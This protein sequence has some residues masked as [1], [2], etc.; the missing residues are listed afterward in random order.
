[1]KYKLLLLALLW[2]VAATAQK[3][4]L[5][6]AELS[7]TAPVSVDN[8]QPAKP[9]DGLYFYGFQKGDV[10]LVNVEPEKAGQTINLE[11]QDYASGSVVYSSKS[12]KKVKDLRLTVPQKAVYSFILTSATG[13]PLAA[14]LSIKRLPAADELRHFNPNITWKNVADT[15]WTTA[16]EKVLVKGELTPT[17][18]IDK[19][20]RVA[21]MANLNPSRVA[22]PFKLPANTVHWV[23]W[24]GVG[25]QSVEDLKNMTKMVTKGASL[26]A[27]ST[28][29]PL[30]GFGLGLIPNLPQVA[31]S[32]NIDYYF[33]NKASADKFVAGEEGWKPYT[34][35][36]G[37]GIVS[38]YKKVSLSETPK[39]AD[40]TLYA[41]FRNSNTVTG[42]DITLKIVAFEQEK[43][44]VT[45]QV[46]KPA[47]IEQKLVPIFGE[48]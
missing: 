4:A 30:V 18:L 45:R 40:G 22:V 32:G 20:F 48:N 47:K 15:T 11:V 46:R 26:V 8:P 38:D 33:M 13:N 21:S 12:I 14:R 37:T 5:T 43:K 10:V 1:M 2:G 25:Q 36:Q 9:Q 39:T 7:I 17:T 41:T 34:F 24:V 16:S 27:S 3:N 28:V 29:G 23:Y 31:A 42:L 35:A 44:Y 6:V 19:T